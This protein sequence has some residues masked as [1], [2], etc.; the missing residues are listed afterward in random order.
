[1]QVFDDIIIGAGSAG[2]VLAN[3]LSADPKTR[4]CLL[5][6]GGADRSAL[7]SIPLGVMALSRQA[8]HN[9]MFA[10]TPQTALN[11]REIAVPRGKTLG[12]S[13][14]ING[15]IYIRGHRE[16]YDAWARAGCSG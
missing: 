2:A 13:S 5:E 11:G 16:D 9:W 8:A 6:G 12:G 7:I 15:M 3:R 4:V 10:T 14:A 1:M